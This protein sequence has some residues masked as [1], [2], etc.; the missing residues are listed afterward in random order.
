MNN[1]DVFCKRQCIIILL[2]MAFVQCV[3]T[4]QRYALPKH[5]RLHH[6]YNTNINY[7]ITHIHDYVC[8]VPVTTFLCNNV[9]NVCG[10]DTFLIGKLTLVMHI[11]YPSLIF[12]CSGAKFTLLGRNYLLSLNGSSWTR[13][14]SKNKF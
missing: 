9:A 2:I 11:L 7:N 3:S 8:F 12:F 5:P 1:L 10:R 14:A 13:V 4:F 6:R